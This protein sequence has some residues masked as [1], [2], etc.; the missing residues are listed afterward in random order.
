[1]I[2]E[3]IA[4]TRLRRATEQDR[5]RVLAE[6]DSLPVGQRAGIGQF[7]V[8]AI[9]E[10]SRERHDGIVWRLRSVRGRDGRTHLGF[11]ACSHPWPCA[12]M[13]AMAQ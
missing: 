7:M 6:L 4:G 9:A 3:D 10:V 2:F 8:D 1:L 13:N 5:L 11:G 12:V